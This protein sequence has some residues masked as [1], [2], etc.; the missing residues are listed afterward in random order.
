MSFQ[1]IQNNFLV[2]KKNSLELNII[3]FVNLCIYRFS[4]CK[5]EFIGRQKL[6]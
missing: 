5:I 6:V 2:S 1:N 4:E 3:V